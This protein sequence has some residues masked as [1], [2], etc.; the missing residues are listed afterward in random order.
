MTLRLSLA[1]MI[2]AMMPL[3]QARASE[4]NAPELPRQSWSFDG[5]FGTYD[6]AALQR[7]FKVYRDVCS[8]CHSM[9]LLYYR[10]LEGIGY[11][12]AQIKNIAADYTIED[13]PNDEGDMFERPRLPSDHFKAP[14]AN[15]KAAAYA[16]NG[17]APPDLSLIAKAREGHADYIYALLTSFQNPPP[18]GANLAQGQYWNEYFPGHK[19]A[20]PPPLSD[21]MVAYEDGTPETLNQYARDVAQFLTWAGDPY[22]EER[23]RT[24]LKVLLFLLVFASVMYA[25]KRKIWADQH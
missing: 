5:P 10:D 16:N 7:G 20:M 3:A 15:A 2:L 19:L 21:G 11:N 6:K 17:A 12:E 18:H 8:S 25:V 24:G 14:F 13:G 23:K 22:M 4:A 9:N 1:L